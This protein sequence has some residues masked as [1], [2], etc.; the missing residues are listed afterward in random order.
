MQSLISSLKNY[1]QQEPLTAWAIVIAAVGILILLIILW[2]SGWRFRSLK[3]VKIGPVEAER[4]E[5]I[6]KDSAL[7]KESSGGAVTAKDVN[8]QVEHSTFHD[9]VGDIGGIIVKGD[10]AGKRK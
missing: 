9:Q 5:S 4:F 8:V 3:K 7:P 2:R 1:F 6:R 10:S